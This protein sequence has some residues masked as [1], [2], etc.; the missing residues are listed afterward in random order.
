MI[1]T[2]LLFGARSRGVW[3]LL[4]A[5]GL[6]TASWLAF[7]PVDAPEGIEHLDKVRHLMAF[8]S[9]ALAASF[10]WSAT[11]RSTVFIA[12]GLMAYGL[13]IELVQ[14]QLPTRSGSGADWLADAVGVAAGMLLA[15]GLRPQG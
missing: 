3:R 4:L 1:D 10:S 14:T 13:F 7:S 12:A 9:L 6:A 15:R 8:A 5:T 2:R 11:R